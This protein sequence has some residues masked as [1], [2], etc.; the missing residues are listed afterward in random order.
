[1]IT[2]LIFYPY[3]PSINTYIDPKDTTVSY[4][5][6]DTVVNT[7]SKLERGPAFRLNL[8]R[9]IPWGFWISRSLVWVLTISIKYCPFAAP[10]RIKSFETFPKFVELLV[11]RQSGE[12]SQY[13]QDDF[14]FAGRFETCQCQM[15]V[16]TFYSLY[17]DMGIPLEK[18]KAYGH[19]H[20]Y[21]WV[22]SRIQLKC[23][24][25]RNVVK[26]HKSY[27]EKNNYQKFTTEHCR[28]T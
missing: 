20:L 16:D 1:M 7:S 13:Y 9:L 14:I 26:S 2:N 19:H 12:T 25:S 18:D 4:T 28:Q 5:C 21:S 27:S 6:F 3:S 24:D 17:T 23:K 15:L 22:C 8:R 10:F 11:R